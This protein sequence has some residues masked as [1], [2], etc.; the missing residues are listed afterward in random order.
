MVAKNEKEIRK[1]GNRHMCMADTA[2]CMAETNTTLY[3][4]Y[5][6][7]KIIFLKK[8]RKLEKKKKKRKK[9]K[10]PRNL[11]SLFCFE[12]LPRRGC[13]TSVSPGRLSSQD[14]HLPEQPLGS[15][16]TSLLCPAALHTCIPHCCS[17]NCLIFP[18]FQLF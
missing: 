15:A 12:Q 13:I 18:N 5:I 4:N 2:C 7:I 1:G 11:S 16:N 6:P 3:S 10:K 8:M 17:V 14:P 9:E